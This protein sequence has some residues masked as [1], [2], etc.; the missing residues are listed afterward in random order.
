M[1]GSVCVT[2]SRKRRKEGGREATWSEGEDK[3]CIYIF[4]FVG[5]G[6]VCRACACRGSDVCVSVR[7]LASL[8]MY[9]RV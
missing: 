1:R 9:S 4:I 8:C 2:R 7:D 5:E 6:R 3:K